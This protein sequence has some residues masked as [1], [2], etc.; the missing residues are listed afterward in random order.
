MET[1][2][3]S[4]R[5]FLYSNA[6]DAA[7]RSLTDFTVDLIFVTTLGA[8]AWQMGLLNTLGSLAFLV[9]TIPIG[10]FVDRYRP[11]RL[12]RFGL[13]VKVALTVCLL[14]LAF[15]GTLSIGYGFLLVTLLGVCNVVAETAQVSA[16]PQLNAATGA[17]RPKSISGLIARLT[18]ADQSLAIIIPVVAGTAFTILGASTLLTVSAV[19]ALIALSMACLVK[20]PQKTSNAD[21]RERDTHW[22]SGL[23]YLR[24]DRTLVAVTLAVMCSNFGL[25]VGSAVEALFIINYLDF[26]SLGFG[27]LTGLGGAGG[28]LGAAL[29]TRIV[30]RYSATQLTTVTMAIKLVLAAMVF[31]AAFTPTAVSMS[32]LAVQ[33][34]L[35]GVALIVFNIAAAAWVADITPEALLGR[36]SSARRLFTFGVVPVGSL[37]GGAIGT[38]FGLPVALALWPLSIAVGLLGYLAIRPR[39]V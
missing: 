29:A 24:H 21:R 30:V 27:I 37:V 34:V 32:L 11:L 33:S 12:L 3:R 18:A 25:A 38:V 6:G 22:L 14:L 9:A 19:L 35:W 26:G 1:N 23:K 36:V 8:S 4:E 10:Y 28:L 13:S 2:L 31:L 15:T 16:V 7:N 39:K 20:I 5:R 17:E